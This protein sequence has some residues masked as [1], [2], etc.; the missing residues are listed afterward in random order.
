MITIVS[1][2]YS[3]RFRNIVFIFCSPYFYL[4]LYSVISYPFPSTYGQHHSFPIGMDLPE[5]DSLTSP[6]SKPTFPS[7]LQG[8]L[9]GAAMSCSSF[10]SSIHGLPFPLFLSCNELPGLCGSLKVSSFCFS[11]FQ[12]FPSLSLPPSPTQFYLCLNMNLRVL[13]F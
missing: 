13:K 8:T 7:F 3:V 2:L 11:C 10:I 4:H 6:L 9:L 5:F 12:S 1:T